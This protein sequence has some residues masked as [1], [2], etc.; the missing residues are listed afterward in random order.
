[1]NL[2]AWFIE[3]SFRVRR[4]ER[5]RE[6]ERDLRSRRGEPVLCRNNR[7]RVE[8]PVYGVTAPYLFGASCWM[9]V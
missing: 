5:E 7:K 4:R 1:V 8:S 6:R 9:S 3:V 2:K